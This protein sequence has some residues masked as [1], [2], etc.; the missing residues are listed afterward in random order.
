MADGVLYLDIDDEITS[1]AARVR[2]VAGGRVAVVLPYGSRVATSRINF[3]L[4]A[5]DALTH[6]KRLSII[7]SDSATRALAASAGLPVF[8]SVSEYEAS[9]P[10][11]R[12]SATD[13]AAGAAIAGAGSAAAV[14]KAKRAAG[15]GATDASQEAIWSETARVEAPGGE[16]VGGEASTGRD[17]N[18]D[19][20]AGT[21]AVAA[22]AAIVGAGVA[23]GGAFA[24]E[25]AGSAP[26]DSGPTSPPIPTTDGRRR[27]EVTATKSRGPGRRGPIA[28]GLAV[29][30]LALLVGIVGA[31]LFLPSATIVVTPRTRTVGPIQLVVVADP[32]TTQ[33]DPSAPSVPAQTLSVDV[34]AS[35]TFP[36]TGKRVA[37]T[38]ATG[39]VRFQNFD[40]TPGVSNTIPAGSIVSTSS[41]I[42]FRTNR[43][44]TIGEATL[45]FLTGKVTP[46]AALVGVTA[47][48]PGPAGNV[49]PDTIRTI[50][51][52]EGPFLLVTN[53]NATTGG[54]RQEF[55]QVTQADVDAALVALDV[56]LHTDFAEQVADP[57]L[58]P[59]GSTVFPGT[60]KLGPSTPT[61]DPATL[62]GTEAATFDLGATATGTVLAVDEAPLTSIAEMRLRESVASGSQLVEDSI[63]ITVGTAVVVGDKVTFPVT[64]TATQVAVLDAAELKTMVLGKTKAEA[65]VIL[66][67][68]GTSVITLSP[69]WVGTIPTFENRV[70]LTVEPGPAGPTGSPG[71]SPSP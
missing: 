46:T 58:P 67:P 37:E 2:A 59:A 70:E 62:V 23:D 38:A 47:V 9:L 63:S 50:P 29:L 14:R 13:V 69:D 54:T 51:P 33:P 11:P 17:A 43:S 28:V 19:D 21:A 48:K 8:A 22:S 41:G 15:S 66:A 52:G 10:P 30:G 36:A 39:I 44:V 71:V 24:A 45:D 3:R 64:A 42:H 40:A 27:A 5:R 26:A 35:D 65:T 25:S 4:L 34:S 12:E 56:T 53:P 16:A 18:D 20:R 7:A 49:G 61:V 1:A 32:T 31:Y 6:E 60:A 55:P 57:A 68:Y